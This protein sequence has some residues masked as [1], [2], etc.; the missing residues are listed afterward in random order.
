MSAVFVDALDDL[1]RLH[2]PIFLILLV[3]VVVIVDKGMI[4]GPVVKDYL[5]SLLWHVIVGKAVCCC[6]L[7]ES[8]HN[9]QRL[10][11]TE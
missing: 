5:G 2:D 10:L 1:G 3:V 4:V 7:R 6:L 9:M 11:V 8:V